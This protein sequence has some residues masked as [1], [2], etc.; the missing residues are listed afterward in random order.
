MDVGVY[1][2]KRAGCVDSDMSSQEDL[3]TGSTVH[4]WTIHVEA[5]RSSTGRIRQAMCMWPNE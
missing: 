1:T 5:R 2:S 3:S 4:C